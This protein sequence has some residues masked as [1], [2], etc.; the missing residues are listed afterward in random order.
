MNTTSTATPL[1]FFSTDRYVPIEALADLLKFDP[2]IP[3]SEVSAVGWEDKEIVVDELA[4][5]FPFPRNFNREWESVKPTLAD[6]SSFAKGRLLVIRAANQI[7][8]AE[9]S[10]KEVLGYIASLYDA[11]QPPTARVVIVLDGFTSATLQLEKQSFNVASLQLPAS[12]SEKVDEVYHVQVSG[13]RNHTYYVN[14]AL[15]IFQRRQWYTV[16]ELSGL[17]NAIPSIVSIAEILKRYKVATV[18]KIETSLVEL[19]DGEGSRPLQKAKMVVFM[20]KIG[21]I[22][23]IP[24]D[25]GDQVV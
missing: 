11:P 13:K 14:L 4:T 23:D 20:D 19:S 2:E 12:A 6:A 10:L 7:G 25:A 9:E 1:E 16:L 15:K 8:A 24:E 21:S 22:P 3:Q 5:F 17:G 18:K